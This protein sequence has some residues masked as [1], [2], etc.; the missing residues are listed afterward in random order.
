MTHGDDFALTGPT[1][2]L[3]EFENK[4]PGVY[5]V[6]AKNHQLRVIKEHQSVEQKVAL[7]DGEELFISTI[8]DTLTCL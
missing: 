5:P 1:K 7:G 6:K 3:T 8:S 4:M 2:R